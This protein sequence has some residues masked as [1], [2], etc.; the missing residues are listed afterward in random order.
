MCLWHDGRVKVEIRKSEDGSGLLRCTRDD[1][2]VTWQKQKKHGAHFALHDLTHLTVESVLGFRN[3]F[4][5]LISQGWDIEDTSGKGA[6]GPLPEEAIEVEY[7]VGV[8]DTERNCGVVFGSGE[9]NGTT[10]MNAANSG[11]RKPRE[12]SEAELA[13]LRATRAELFDEWR[14]TPVGGTLKVEFPRA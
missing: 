5:G 9:F 11:R 12:V 2:S 4:Y 13:R 14:A 6:R 3:G 10:A 7:L 8:L 1:G